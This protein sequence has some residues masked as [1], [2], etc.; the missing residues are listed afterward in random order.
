MQAAA[1]CRTLSRTLVLAARNSRP[2]HTTVRSLSFAQPL[3]SQRLYTEKHEWVSVNGKIGTVGISQHAQEALGDIVYAELPEVGAK[4]QKDDSAG[5]LESVK[6]ASDVYSPVSGKVTERNE[7]VEKEPG[8]INK[9][10]YEKGWL[11]KLELEDP[12][13]LKSLMD[14]AAYEKFLKSQESH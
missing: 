10:V 9:F 14:D 6:A 8:L 12:S 4:L 3:S 11:F 5:A 13:E 7:A 2:S 1:A